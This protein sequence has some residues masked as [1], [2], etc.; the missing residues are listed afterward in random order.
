M[1]NFIALTYE[2]HYLFFQERLQEASRDL[3]NLNDAAD[4]VMLLD[5]IDAESIPFKI[6]SGFMHMD[7]V[8]NAAS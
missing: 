2:I 7:Q 8:S 4:E 1:Q 5:D 3:Q 6:G